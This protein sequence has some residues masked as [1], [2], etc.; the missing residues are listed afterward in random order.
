M[1]WLYALVAVVAGLSNPLQSGANSEFVKHTG[2]VPAA[3]YVYAT[4]AI[5]LVLAIPFFGLGGITR[6]KLANVP[7]WAW[8]GGLCNVTFL[9]ATLTVTKKLGSALFTT[10]VVITAV[11]LSLALDHFGLM[12]F[13]QRSA[14]AGRLLGG[15][16]AIAGIVCIARF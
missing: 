10:L 3:F 14:T 6:E 2:V 7:W 8:V 15:A 11:C 4:G 1:T 5:V 9:L 16:L 12:G 13:E